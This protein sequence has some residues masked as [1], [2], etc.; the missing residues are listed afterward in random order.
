MTE[1]KASK[2]IISDIDGVVVEN[3]FTHPGAKDRT[4]EFLELLGSVK[5][6]PEYVDAIVILR[7]AG[8]A[9][10]F[11]TGRD[12][13]LIA[14]TR[15]HLKPFQAGGYKLICVSFRGFEQYVTDKIACIEKIV[16]KYK[17]VAVIDD[18]REIVDRVESD[19][20]P[21]YPKKEI[22]TVKYPEDFEK[23]LAN[24]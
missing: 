19:I 12:D 3:T 10:F 15:Q 17:K 5:P 21:K 23:V 2:A 22:I 6:D 1:A 13:G 8:Y 9:L 4:P 16:R 14:I 20:V 24:I 11:A 18:T 7:D